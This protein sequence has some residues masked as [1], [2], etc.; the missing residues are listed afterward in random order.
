MCLGKSAERWQWDLQ[1]QQHSCYTPLQGSEVSTSSIAELSEDHL[2]SEWQF[3]NQC[4]WKPSEERIDVTSRWD[5]VLMYSLDRVCVTS[6]AVIF[7]NHSRLHSW[8]ISSALEVIPRREGSTCLQ[9]G[10][11]QMYAAEI[12]L[13][14]WKLSPPCQPVPYVCTLS[15]CRVNPTVMDF[16]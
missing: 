8:V 9:W 12:H 16:P 5:L 11:L 10:E 4:T 15:G 1:L 13:Q 6:D 7:S 3:A 14:H 2:P